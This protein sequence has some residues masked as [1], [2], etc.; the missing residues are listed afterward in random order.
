LSQVVDLRI[1]GL[2]WP[3]SRWQPGHQ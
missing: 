3:G 1:R 2:R